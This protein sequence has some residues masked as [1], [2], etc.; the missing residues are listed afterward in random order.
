MFPVKERDTSETFTAQLVSESFTYPEQ[1]ELPQQMEY[2]AVQSQNSISRYQ[3]E[4]NSFVNN[5]N[6]GSLA[7]ST[8]F[9]QFF[10]APVQHPNLFFASTIS[11]PVNELTLAL[12]HDIPDSP[13]TSYS[14][15]P[16]ESDISYYAYDS[17]LFETQSPFIHQY[18]SMVGKIDPMD[19]YQNSQ[20]PDE[21]ASAPA[22]C[23]ES[24]YNQW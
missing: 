13:T 15:S 19:F 16:A 14:S 17:A 4:E 20:Y 24:S 23:V 11:T 10:A 18:S 3:H 9:T 1:E 2:F 5:S 21:I 8:D 12:S 22:L 6:P 7:I